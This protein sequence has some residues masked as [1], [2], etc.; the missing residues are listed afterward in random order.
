MIVYGSRSTHLK[1][2]QLRNAVCPNCETRGQ[3]TASVYGRHAHIFW[4][5]FFPMG[6]TGILECQHCHKGYKPK[7][8]DDRAKTEY[9][10]FRS[11]VKTP[12]WKY[13]G[14][15]IVAL[16]IGAGIYSN[17][18]TEDKVNKLVANPAMFDKYTFKTETNYY[19]TFKVVEVFKDSIYV[20]Y[21]DYETDKK[22]GLRDIDLDKN[23][24][25]D[26]YVLTNGDLE[27]LHSA[28]KIEDI[29]RNK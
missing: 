6:K 29:E 28:G 15:G 9:K 8:L 26:I 16:L 23:Y 27:D 7:E 14:L 1:S 11:T 4:I 20:N 22:S 3:M 2:E 12:L 21:N 19:S 24:A 5:P 13:A 25:K 18:M 10:N 17:K